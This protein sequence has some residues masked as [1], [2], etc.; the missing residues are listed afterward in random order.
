[1]ARIP[2][3]QR[4]RVR[5]AGQPKSI[6]DIRPLGRDVSSFGQAIAVR[7]ERL[8]RADEQM[9]QVEL[10]KQFRDMRAD[11]S[12]YK[13]GNA[14]GLTQQFE[15]QRQPMFDTA[16]GNI[17][18][19]VTR[20]NM[21]A[22]FEDQYSRNLNWVRNYVMGEEDRHLSEVD[23]AYRDNAAAKINELM[24]GD[25]ESIDA[26]VDD[27]AIAAGDREGD[28]R[29]TPERDAAYRGAVT[30]E[31]YSDKIT[32]WFR[33]DPLTA[34]N[35]VE[36]NTEMLS[37]KLS[38][39]AYNAVL[40]QQRNNYG[41]A[42][43]IRIEDAARSKWGDDLLTAS[44]R[45]R[46]PEVHRELEVAPEDARYAFE[47]A[48][49]LYNQYN[50][51]QML[52]RKT[53]TESKN[54][55]VDQVNQYITDIAKLKD[56]EARNQSYRNLAD[57]V[58]KEP[59]FN[60]DERKKML[61]SIQQANFYRDPI[62]IRE[63]RADINSGKI[64]EP[65]QLTL[66]LGSGI[67]PDTKELE[68]YL[69]KKRGLDSK[70]ARDYLKEAEDT[71]K[72][73]AVELS[74]PKE[75]R[76][77]DKIVLR[78]SELP[79]FMRRLEARMIAEDLTANDPRVQELADELMTKQWYRLSREIPGEEPTLVPM[80]EEPSWWQKWRGVAQERYPF[81]AQPGEEVQS[82]LKQMEAGTTPEAIRQGRT[83]TGSTPETTPAVTPP[84][85]PEAEPTVTGPVAGSP[86][87]MASEFLQLKANP[88]MIPGETVEQKMDY[89]NGI[90]Q[91]IYGK[92][93]SDEQWSKLY[94]QV[95]ANATSG[96]E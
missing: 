55:L 84:A 57:A 72:A 64:T 8:R 14:L 22:Y 21:E 76:D 23:V 53:N 90:F 5:F 3:L 38:P 66:L 24:I 62:R 77:P 19:P 51:E 86:E 61:D 33:Q 27:V 1:M 63:V 4:Q 36:D 75:R 45:L 87:H 6:I 44:V 93:M 15:G 65:Y 25:T 88:Y 17:E 94:I 37:N 92:P 32:Q 31:F 29:W 89:L 68:A 83:A 50:M 2:I 58:R 12:T 7:H 46:D 42:Q 59:G 67:G 71:Y 85:T 16:V 43:I 78:K 39:S 30:D 60:P 28:R 69:K 48:N 80:Q 82:I 52:A 56:P 49:R 20:S 47:V 70:G 26:L 81:E 54:A 18:D 74:T 79:H 40:Q 9:R 73:A 91:K 13:A 41:P 11:Y 95:E 34:Y 96:P 35:W 10:D